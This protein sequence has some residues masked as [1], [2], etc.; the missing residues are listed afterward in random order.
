MYCQWQVD[1]SAQP[2]QKEESFDTP[3]SKNCCEIQL[4][5]ITS[6]VKYLASQQFSFS[7]VATLA[8]IKRDHSSLKLNSCTGSYFHYLYTPFTY[9]RNS[10]KRALRL[11]IWVSLFKTHPGQLFDLNIQLSCGSWWP[12]YYEV[13]KL[14]RFYTHLVAAVNSREGVFSPVLFK[15]KFLLTFEWLLVIILINTVL[16]NTCR[17]TDRRT[18]RR[19]D[20]HKEKREI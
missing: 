5:S 12:H 2:E 11:Q 16:A 20:T 9:V 3:S 7:Y 13:K 15:R 17:Q 10:V 18:D 19:T 8:L 1:T 6:V 14:C 4:D